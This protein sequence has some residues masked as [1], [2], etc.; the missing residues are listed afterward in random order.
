M[1][2]SNKPN[3]SSTKRKIDPPP[4]VVE[5]MSKDFGVLVTGYL[6]EAEIKGYSVVGNIYSDQT[7][8]FEDGARIQTS[9][10]VGADLIH[11][12]VVIETFNSRYVICDVSFDEM[13]GAS[14]RLH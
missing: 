7:R 11:G 6:S 12:L 3:G 14:L 5:A 1:G 13:L 2:R 8:R 9:S 4:A 10:V